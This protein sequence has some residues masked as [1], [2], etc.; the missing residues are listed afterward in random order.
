ML[1]M[2]LTCCLP[3]LLVRLFTCISLSVCLCNSAYLLSLFLIC[4]CP[5]IP[6]LSLVDCIVFLTVVRLRLSFLSPSLLLLSL[7]LSSGHLSRSVCAWPWVSA[8]CC[9][10]VCVLFI[11]VCAALC[12]CMCV[13]VCGSVCLCVRPLCLSVRLFVSVR[14]ALRVCVCGSVCLCVRLFVS[15]GGCLCVRLFALSLCVRDSM[16]VCAAV[17]VCVSQAVSDRSGIDHPLCRQCSEHFA[18]KLETQKQV[19][20]RQTDTETDTERRT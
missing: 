4:V 8:L 12:V 11:F 18:S 19:S 6:C 17:R 13:C 16:R 10:F 15:V 7:C 1:L 3:P 9:V 2:S 20:E 14:A 5:V